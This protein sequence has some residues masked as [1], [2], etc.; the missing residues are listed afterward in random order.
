MHAQSHSEHCAYCVQL[1]R[2]RFKPGNRGFTLRETRCAAEIVW[3]MV[4]N[5]LT[6]PFAPSVPP[7]V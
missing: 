1:N 4:S 3:L 5:G 2:A 6:L 7:V